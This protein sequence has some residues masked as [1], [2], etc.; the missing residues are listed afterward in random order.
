RASVDS[1]PYAH[2]YA[3]QKMASFRD[4]RRYQSSPAD[5]G[6]ALPVR[7]LT[8]L[9][10]AVAGAVCFALLRPSSPLSLES[11]TQPRFLL[12]PLGRPAPALVGGVARLV[13]P[14]THRAPNLSIRPVRVL[15]ADGRDVTP[16]GA[17]WSVSHGQLELRLDDRRLS[18]P[19]VIDPAIVFDGANSGSNG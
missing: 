8:L 5:G 4:L 16:K 13:D 11:R 10:L 15:G 19:Y 9:S 14:K 2:A 12:R 3:R 17:R 6:R 7:A 18:A 1:C